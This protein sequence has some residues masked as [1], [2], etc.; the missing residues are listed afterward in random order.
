MGKIGMKGM[1]YKPISIQYHLNKYER[2]GLLMF[3]GFATVM[4]K[5]FF[6]RNHNIYVH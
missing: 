1:V 2:D 4:G 5:T 3:I 6:T